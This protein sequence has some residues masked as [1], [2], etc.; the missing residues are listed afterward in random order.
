[1]SL[2]YPQMFLLLFVVAW[3]YRVSNRRSKLLFGALVLVVVALTRPV[4]TTHK[5]QRVDARE[6]IVAVDLSYSMM[7]DDL[8]PNR[9]EVAKQKLATLLGNYPDDRF[10]LLAFTTNPLILSPSTTDH[11]LI[12]DALNAIKVENILTKGT[13]FLPL[14]K[15][16]AKMQTKSK[17]LIIFSDGGDI[18]SG[19]LEKLVSMAKKEGIK[20]YAVTVATKEGSTIKDKFGN[21]LK[22]DG[23]LV[24]SRAN[25]LFGEFA[26]QSGGRS[27]G[28]KDALVLSEIST[29][30]SKKRTTIKE[31][32]FINPLFLAM[33]LVLIYF[34]R[35]PKKLL[36]L[37]PFLANFSDAGM[38]DWY[39]IKKANE[40]YENSD[41]KASL[42]YFERVEPS[43]ERDFNL[44]VIY[45]KLGIYSKAKDILL[46]FSTKDPKKKQKVFFM[47]GNIEAQE[48]SYTKAKQ[49]Y[50]MALN[51]GYKKE[52]IENI[53]TIAFE[54]DSYKKE[55]K[56]QGAKVKGKIKEQIKHSS[57]GAKR[58][59]KG[60]SDNE[61]LS[62]VI[63]YK[64]YELI[65]KGYIDEKNPW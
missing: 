55:E 54:K 4:I 28:V 37:V 6:F 1:M 51:L 14:L 53:K 20:V 21:L 9:L 63:G 2:L 12:I 11:R 25:P 47:L 5:K 44:A 38:L 18:D 40:L 29:K 56:K 48:K 50:M 57:K 42:G 45:Y 43:F 41:A 65:N 31:E 27:F 24:I 34:V 39:Y 64:A 59:K 17:N 22:Q 61:N 58:E 10:A 46:N 52:I 8:K 60:D 62:R 35:I 32:L 13:H 3:L 33:I 16:V 49:F 36:L 23:H 19:S 30:E 7:A 26:K 15:R